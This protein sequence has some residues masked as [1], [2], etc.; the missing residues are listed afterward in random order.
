MIRKWLIKHWWINEIGKALATSFFGV[1]SY[2]LYVSE[3][4]E[5]AFVSGVIFV[6]C[7]VCFIDLV[8]VLIRKIMGKP[9]YEGK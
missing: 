8:T 7:M 3:Q 2:G 4:R 6:A 5:L 1:V 9:I